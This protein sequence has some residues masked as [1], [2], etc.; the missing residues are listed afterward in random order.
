MTILNIVAQILLYVNI[1]GGLI[2]GVTNLIHAI[3]NRGK[4]DNWS[5]W[6]YAFLG[7]YWAVVYSILKFVPLN[8]HEYA[9]ASTWIR[10]ATTMLIMLVLIESVSNFQPVYLPDVIKNYIQKLKEKG[11]K[12]G[13]S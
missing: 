5:K 9:F 8:N 13:N 4:L 11:R 3:R 1:L 6:A 10:P 12:Y 7:F 2:V